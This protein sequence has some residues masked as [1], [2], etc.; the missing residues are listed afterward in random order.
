[1]EVG[2][3]WLRAGRGGGEAGVPTIRLVWPGSAR[4]GPGVSCHRH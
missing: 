3:A 2:R 1:M 4:P